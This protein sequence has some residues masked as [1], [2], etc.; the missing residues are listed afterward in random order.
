M[1]GIIMTILT[2]AILGP[3]LIAELLKKTG[4]TQKSVPV[5]Q[6]GIYGVVI[7]VF[8]TFVAV[9]WLKDQAEAHTRAET[10][11][12]IAAATVEKARTQRLSPA[13]VRSMI[14]A[15]KV[16]GW[17]SG[18]PTEYDTV[19]MYF[20]G[21]AFFQDKW[22]GE[23]FITKEDQL[24]AALRA[25][26]GDRD[27]LEK[28]ALTCLGTQQCIGVLADKDLPLFMSEAT[29]LL[30]RIEKEHKDAATAACTLKGFLLRNLAYVGDK[31]VTL[32]DAVQQLESCTSLPEFNSVYLSRASSALKAA[33]AKSN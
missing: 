29:R 25:H 12:H 9:M 14:E 13:Q 16:W 7:A 27:G 4:I 19:R 31:A 1:V 2:V 5:I 17:E 23:H 15:E 3:L 33:Q 24:I 8:G 10:Q 32:N 30:T 22:E 26:R 20:K 28:A 21:S 18:A 6:L 11:Q